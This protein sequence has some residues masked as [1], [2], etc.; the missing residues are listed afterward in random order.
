MFILILILIIIATSYKSRAIQKIAK[1]K[2]Q[3][4]KNI[5]S[6]KFYNAS[7]TRNH[8][9]VVMRQGHAVGRTG[10]PREDTHQW[11]H[12]SEVDEV[13]ECVEGAAKTFIGKG[14]VY[15]ISINTRVDKAQP[16]I[17]HSKIS[18]IL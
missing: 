7:V 4:R 3:S 15:I 9:T 12:F 14:W 8:I 6:S 18:K 11:S 16:K 17:A 13:L 10:M 2:T 1:T 5:V